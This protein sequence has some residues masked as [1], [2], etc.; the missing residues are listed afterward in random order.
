MKE[1]RRIM[2][3]PEIFM[4]TGLSDATIW[5]MEKVDNFPRRI[6]LGGKSV[7][8]FSDEIEKWF[9]EKSKNR[10]KL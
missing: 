3:K 7:G 4:L 6:Q 8:W 9:E 5:R 1:G 10:V 2:R